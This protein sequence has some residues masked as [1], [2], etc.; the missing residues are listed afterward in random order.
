MGRGADARVS[1][2]QCRGETAWDD[3]RSA[4]FDDGISEL[5]SFWDHEGVGYNIRLSLFRR[6]TFLGRPS[7]HTLDE[8]KL[9]RFCGGTRGYR[10]A[11]ENVG[12]KL[13]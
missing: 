10:A 1:K 9:N 6:A 5:M 7:S 11:R 13:L 3:G 2:E 12:Q 4:C 8:G